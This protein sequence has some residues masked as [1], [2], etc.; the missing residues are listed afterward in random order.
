MMFRVSR[1]LMI[2]ALI[3]VLMVGCGGSRNEDGPEDAGAPGTGSVSPGETTASTAEGGSTAD[4]GNGTAVDAESLRDVIEELHG[5]LGTVGEPRFPVGF[6]ASEVVDGIP[7]DVVDNFNI[8]AEQVFAWVVYDG[9]QS[10]EIEAKLRIPSR[11]QPI[12]SAE[13]DISEGHGWAAFEFPQP[14][15]GWA[16]GNYE[17]VISAGGIE[18]IIE[19]TMNFHP[20]HGSSLADAEGRIQLPGAASMPGAVSGNWQMADVP[21]P[22]D[23]FGGLIVE[24]GRCLAFNTRGELAVSDDGESW[25]AVHHPF[26][27]AP[28]RFGATNG[29][30]FGFTSSRTHQYVSGDGTAWTRFEMGTHDPLVS[31]VYT[32]DGYIGGD[33]RRIMMHSEDGTN[34]Q[35]YGYERENYTSLQ[36]VYLYEVNRYFYHDGRHWFVKEDGIES[37]TVLHDP[38][39]WIP[40]GEDEARIA[41]AR[42]IINGDTIIF[43]RH[44][45]K[46]LWEF[47]GNGFSRIDTDLGG[48]VLSSILP[49]NGGY[50]GVRWDG[51]VLQSADAVDWHIVTEAPEINKAPGASAIVGDRVVVIFGGVL[52]STL[53][54]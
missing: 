7:V 3:V 18:Y 48:D 8:G 44:G 47:T 37:G 9:L 4:T 27:V 40:F 10:G 53:L 54:D 15:S 51:A 41:N 35:R 16:A 39:I 42:V 28:T 5:T 12:A 19:F 14:D 13:A 25:E 38:N 24:S 36:N 50:V 52:Y 2:L 34:W 11:D 20:S 46:E 6:M 17:T 21:V 1:I 30:F 22:E 45:T 49:R 32:H 23:G 31:I 43:W 29:R 33:E 26:E